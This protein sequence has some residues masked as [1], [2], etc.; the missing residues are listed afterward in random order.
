MT[1]VVRRRGRSLVDQVVDTIGQDI[2]AGRFPPASQLPNETEWIERL[3]VSRSVLREALRVLV[4]KGLI[5]IRART[6]GRVRD[7]ADWNLLDPD[8]LHWRSHSGDQGS[9]VTELFELRRVIEPAAAGLAASRITKPQLADLAA[10]LDAMMAAGE[11]SERFLEPDARFHRIILA[12]VGNSLFRALGQTV[13]VALDIT[14]RLSLAAPQGQQQSLP[15]HKTVLDAIASRDSAAASAAM[16]A[17]VNASE[18]DVAEAQ[19]APA[20]KP[21]PAR[22]AVSK[23]VRT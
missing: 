19:A 7:D 18:R 21:G 22:R 1:G 17:L 3:E 6:G 9:F 12:S 23:T 11:D 16:L 20:K 14:L 15:F 2:V 5:D 13:T 4:S 10:A 8:I